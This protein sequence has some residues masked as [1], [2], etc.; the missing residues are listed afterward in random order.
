[1]KTKAEIVKSITELN[2]LGDDRPISIC[3]SE[4]HECMDEYA[5]EY[6][7]TFIEYAFKGTPHSR[8][9]EVLQ[10]FKESLKK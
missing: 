4:I 9:L 5:E 3:H 1:M 2:Y 7:K 6:A 8:L 10:E